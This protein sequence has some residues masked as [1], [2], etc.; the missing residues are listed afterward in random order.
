[1]I[2]HNLSCVEQ[3]FDVVNK[4]SFKKSMLLIVSL[5]TAAIK[6]NSIF[7][8]GMTNLYPSI[9]TLRFQST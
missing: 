4:I 6:Q 2:V 7:I 5:V 8:L 1:M 9:L 3:Y